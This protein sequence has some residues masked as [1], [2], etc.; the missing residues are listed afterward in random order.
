MAAAPTAILT[1]RRSNKAKPRFASGEKA[2]R[3]PDYR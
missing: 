3:D 1:I 2:R